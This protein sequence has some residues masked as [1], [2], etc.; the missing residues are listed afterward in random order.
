MQATE[1]TPAADIAKLAPGTQV[2]V[3][4]KLRCGAPLTG[5]FSQS[6]CAH[7]SATIDREYETWEYDIKRK[8]SRRVRKTA[9]VEATLRCVPFEVEDDSGK[10]AVVP[11]EA[12]VEGVEAVNRYETP[13][14]GGAAGGLA[15]GALRALAPGDQ[16]LGLRYQET[17]LPIGVDVYVLGV[18]RK[19]G[20]IGAPVLGANGQSFVISTK[21]E[22]ARAASLARS[23]KWTLGLGIACLVAGIASLAAAYWVTPPGLPPIP[24]DVPQ[25]ETSW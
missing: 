3:K 15:E 8:T 25:G 21:S 10:I 5:A 16:T 6:P 7:Y 23:A 18:T 24:Q 4:G 11:E 20:T 12:L 17:H 22:E 14:E 1:T 9:R 2:E 13:R 19:D